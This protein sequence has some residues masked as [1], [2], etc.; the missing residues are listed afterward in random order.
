MPVI[1]A[2]FS[3]GLIFGWGPLPRLGIAVPDRQL[4]C[5]PIDSPEA[6]AYLGQVFATKYPTRIRRMV[7]DANV[8]RNQ[9][10]VIDGE[11]IG[12]PSPGV[13]GT[14]RARDEVERAA[15]AGALGDHGRGGRGHAGQV[16]GVANHAVDGLAVAPVGGD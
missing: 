9:W 12:H 4:A 10:V 14:K 11:R 2:A 5:A 15:R 7:L 8:G 1:L 13:T 3:C 6:R 16:L